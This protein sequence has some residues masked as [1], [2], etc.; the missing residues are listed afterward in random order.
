MMSEDMFLYDTYAIIEIIEGNE[1]YEGYLD[2][3]III[4]DFIFA[5]LSYVL[6][7][8]GYPDSD[9]YIQK[10]MKYVIHVSP[11]LIKKAMEF[12]YKNKEKGMSVTDCISYFQARKLGI[13][14]LTGDKEFEDL[15]NVEFVK[16]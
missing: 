7:R 10:Y 2:K 13:R 11:D 9:K 12:R 3:R 8:E 14:F 6:I 15:D 1:N 5:E 4:N 16:K